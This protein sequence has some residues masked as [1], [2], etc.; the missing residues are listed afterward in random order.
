[1]E[2]GFV[3]GDIC[4]AAGRR[5]GY[6]RAFA[7]FYG[8]LAGVA[9]PVALP[10][11]QTDESL[12]DRL[13][14]LKTSY[15][16]EGRPGISRL[17]AAIRDGN[18][19]ETLAVLEDEALADVARL[20]HPKAADGIVAL[21]EAELESLLGSTTPDEALSRLERFR[22][23]CVTHRGPYGVDNVNRAFDRRVEAR[24]A[25]AWGRWYHGRPV[26]VTVNDYVTGL[27][28]GDVG[29]CLADAE[30]GYAVWFRLADGSTR[31]LPPARLPEYRT[32][33]ALTVHKSQGSEFDRV[34]VV[35]P[36]QDSVLLTRELVYT[37]ATRARSE[38]VFAGPAG[39]IAT[40][41][42]RRADRT[43]GLAELLSQ[44]R[45]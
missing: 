29:V 21:V 25:Q 24:G 39:S 14:E 17:S 41:V 36:E 38:V 3:F 8:A 42:G 16:F 34:V 35:L 40:A 12:A 13:V 19:G 20:E 18:A 10:V 30:L 37:A 31:K 26:I 5:T 4:E 9:L 15:R 1:V 45:V 23:L 43:S 2:A 7:D 11:A 44:P 27:F 22:V 6:S 28:N 32:A 33:W